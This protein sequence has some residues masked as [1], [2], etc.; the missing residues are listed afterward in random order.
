MTTNT[1]TEH[2][3]AAQLA[4]VANRLNLA[5]DARERQIEHAKR[6]VGI[7]YSSGKTFV[8]KAVPEPTATEVQDKV[9]V[10]NG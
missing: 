1:N 6:V 8:L 9:T 7:W 3:S 5:A 2:I 10:I 4:I